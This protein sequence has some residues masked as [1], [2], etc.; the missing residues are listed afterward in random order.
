[1]Q[2]ARRGVEGG[3]GPLVAAL[4]AAEEKPGGGARAGGAA[5][6]RAPGR[7]GGQG[8]AD[9]RTLAQPRGLVRAV[10]PPRP[11]AAR[12][13]AALRAAGCA[14][15]GAEPARDGQGSGR[16]G[17]PQR[18]PARL[19]HES[20]LRV[21]LSAQSIRRLNPQ[22]RQGHAPEGVQGPGSRRSRER[23]E[24]REALAG[25]PGGAAR[26]GRRGGDRRDAGDVHGRHAVALANS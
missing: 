17:R 2:G 7:V 18:V 10:H 11:V 4:A 21:R 14:L 23:G 3:P 8:R 6:G 22:Q 5:G 19:H 26:R 24:R 16:D 25:V 9:V 12:R 15:G 1:D 20:H 13:A